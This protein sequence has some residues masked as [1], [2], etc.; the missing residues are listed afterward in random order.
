MML[1][2]I[3]ILVRKPFE[4]WIENTT[5][6][7]SNL[8]YTAILVIYLLIEKDNLGPKEKYSRLGTPC[9]ILIIIV[10]LINL[11]VAIITMIS[12]IS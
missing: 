11:I 10:L 12:I 6:I 3:F 5:L 8:C 4:G 7:F 9:V 2:A 1:M